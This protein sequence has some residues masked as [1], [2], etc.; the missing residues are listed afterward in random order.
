MAV[1]LQF[2]PGRE[3]PDLLDLPWSVPLA[4]WRHERLV[5]M[6]HGASR[7]VVRFVSEGERIYA[8]KE[9]PQ[10]VAEHEYTM[11]RQ[12]AAEHLPVVE[13]VG[14]VTGRTTDDG[15]PL[16]AVLVTRYLDYSL[17]FAYLFGVEGGQA[18]GRRLLDAGVVLLVRL[19]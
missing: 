8:L 6:V 1:R 13:A 12:L 2:V 3:P 11:L 7:H 4:E 18:L 16:D 5:Q 15:A 17:P 10:R 9:M 14:L 19:H